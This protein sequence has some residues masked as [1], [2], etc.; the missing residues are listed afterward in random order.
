MA[1]VSG[2]P[3][4]L[5]PPPQTKFY[6]PA[7][8][9]VR[10]LAAYAVFF[11]HFNPFKDATSELGISLYEL[12]HQLHI[13]VAVFFVLSGFL[14][15]SRYSAGLK[16]SWNWAKRY[17]QNRFARIYPLYFV[18]T[19]LTFL[20]ATRNPSY[21]IS[22]LWGR[23]ANYPGEKALMVGL[24]LTF[25]RGFFEYFKFS[26]IMQGWTLTVEECFYLSAPLLLYGLHRSRKFLAF[27]PLLLLGIGFGLVLICQSL[28][29]AALSR[30]GLFGSPSFMLLQTFFGRST[31]FIAGMGLALL[32]QRRTRVRHGFLILTVVGT[33]CIGACMLLLTQVSLPG[34]NI[35]G[36]VAYQFALVNNLLLPIGIVLLLWGLIA[37]PSWLRAGLSTRWADLLGKSSYAF[38]LI[39]MGFLSVFLQTH[40]TENLGLLF[41]IMVLVSIALYKFIEH[42]LQVR[43]AAHK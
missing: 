33:A 10:A 12:T 23:A 39:H 22:G 14:I 20:A 40:V 11:H 32:L 27:Y 13:G 1:E 29:V 21:D 2:L 42:P 4:T 35:T 25:L 31:E 26:G 41:A 36:F 5:T 18:L 17:I 15:T 37:E 6:Y 19:V 43:L 38:Y 3:A 34:A 9:G 7:L 30:F 16:L 28:P 24:N 8:T